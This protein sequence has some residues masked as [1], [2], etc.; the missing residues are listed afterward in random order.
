LPEEEQAV[1]KFRS[2]HRE[3]GYRNVTWL[4]NDRDA[5]A[6]SE[7][8]VYKV[9]LKHHLRGPWSTKGGDAASEYQHKPGR[10]HEHWHTDIAYVKSSTSSS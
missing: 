1:I 2:R 6:L 9:L 10:V 5:Q 8:A 4:M 3:V 7:P